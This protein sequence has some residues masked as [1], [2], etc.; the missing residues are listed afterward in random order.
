MADIRHWLYSVS[1]R[2]GIAAA[3]I[4]AIAVGIG[5]NT[6]VLAFLSAVLFEPLPYDKPERLVM[7]WGRVERL[8]L[9]RSLVSPANY[10]DWKSENNVF[11]KMGAYTEQFYNLEPDDGGAAERLSAFGA[12]PS[13]LETLGV[14]PIVGRGLR[15]EHVE[16]DGRDGPLWVLISHGL[17]QRRFGSD[18]EVPGRR[19]VLSGRSAEIVGVLPP[20]FFF[21]NTK[22]DILAPLAFSTEQIRSWRAQRYLTVVARLK[23]G[24]K[25]AGAQ[26]E[27]ETV[28]G[29]LAEVYP[30][31]NKGRTVYLRA[32]DEEAFGALSS[33]LLLL[34]GASIFV[35]LIAAANVSNLQ[36]ARS[37]SRSREFATRLVLGCSRRRLFQ[38][39]LTESLLLGIVGGILGI[40]V[41]AATTPLISLA[42]PVDIP[43]VD[44]DGVDAR[45]LM[46]AVAL[47]VA[48]SLAFG[49]VPA[50]YASRVELSDSLSERSRSSSS[51][52]R[53]RAQQLLVAV[54]V[55]IALVLLFGAGL[56]IKSLEALQRVD[57]GFSARG[58]T[59]TLDLS[60]SIRYGEPT[61][62]ARFFEDLLERINSLSTVHSAG[63]TSHLPLSRESG[64]RSYSFIGRTLPAL[65]EKS[66]GEYRR[67]SAGYFDAMGIPL[68]RGRPFSLWHM[69]ELSAGV[70]IVNEALARQHW[71]H[72]ED[73]L[74]KQL[75]IED[76]PQR[77]R[78]VIGIVGN[79]KHFGL[80][81]PARPELYVP[82]VDRPWPHMT[83]VVRALDGNAGLLLE[84]VHRELDSL[85]RTIPASNIQTVD[86]YIAASTGRRRFSRNLLSAFAVVALVLAGLGVYSV[87]A[88]AVRQRQ[89][90]IGIRVTVG[91]EE[92]HIVRLI[93]R[94]GSRT[95]GV[96]LAMGLAAAAALTQMIAGMLYDVEPL[97]LS[98]VLAVTTLLG[99]TATLA[100]YL[101]GRYASNQ[102]IV[103]SLRL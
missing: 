29:R 76:G 81:A 26:A 42:I 45:V 73:A 72:E 56:M 54:E 33:P 57:P 52:S 89:K 25:V 31:A 60:L 47:T 69:R 82:H 7:V 21:L 55:A 92:R 44:G 88:H 53:T 32:L 70:V 65:E 66:H 36:L 2:P 35:L 64:G 17:W 13:F 94:D 93:L 102:D 24:I 68:K 87:M 39:L 86:Q 71:A 98:V 101:P 15:P 63:V 10:H 48:A 74:G 6:A 43:R 12:T 9:S 40:T 41:A 85:D 78:E 27:M 22:I 14:R 90:E 28:A 97:D 4:A 20:G 38:Q 30:D 95:V 46:G 23:D 80:H 51:K 16:N 62:R 96:G 59:L 84:Q 37:L 1:R 5:A 19:I 8:G 49:L 50:H 18:M 34:Q 11:E 77:V 61:L 75:V 58:E 79:V 103:K 100:C 67:V 91:A 83:L 99:V 3:S